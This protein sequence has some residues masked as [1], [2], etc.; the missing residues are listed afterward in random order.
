MWVI[1]YK[2][3]P[4]TTYELYELEPMSS[5][6]VIGRMDDEEREAYMTNKTKKGCIALYIYHFGYTW[7]ERVTRVD[8]R[9]VK[10]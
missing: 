1:T 2:N 3:K 4:F 6:Y 7:K 10:L 8:V 5:P 9:K